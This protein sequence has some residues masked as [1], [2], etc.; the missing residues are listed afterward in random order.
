MSRKYKILIGGIALIFIGYFALNLFLKNKVEALADQQKE[1]DLSYDQLHVNLLRRSVRLDSINLGA[2]GL[3][4]DSKKAAIKGVGLIKFIFEDNI[5]IDE[6]QIDQPSIDVSDSEN[7]NKTSNKNQSDS[8]DQ[9]IF[10]KKVN[11]KNGRL[12]VNSDKIDELKLHNFRGHLD[13]IK[14]D[15][16]TLKHKIPFDFK[17][18]NVE[19]EEFTYKLNTLQTLKV[20]QFQIHTHEADFTDVKLLPNYSRESYVKIIPYQKDLMNIDLK[21]LKLKDYSFS[22]EKSG[23]LMARKIHLDQVNA[24]IYLN[25]LVKDD[26]NKKKLYSR[27]LREMPF[28][29]NIDTL[30]ISN[31]AINY[32]EVQEKTKKAGKVFFE[33]LNATGTGISNINMDSPD[34]PET[35]LHITSQLMGVAPLD[36][37]WRFSVNDPQDRFRIAGKS[38]H[39]TADAINNFFVA[40]MNMKAEGDPIKKLKFDFHGDEDTA[41]GDFQM[42]YDDLKINVLKKNG[43][44]KNGFLSAIADIFVSHKKTENKKPVTVKDVERDK[45]RSFWNYFW[46]AIFTGLKETML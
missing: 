41:G 26:P 19:G 45:K 8:L 7:S 12:S 44:E 43:E 18:Y 32:K 21:E 36:I 10:I 2:A 22:L 33:N 6:F 24:Y 38:Q 1:W 4:I 29:L 9:T 17:S 35:K 16:H 46:T 30:Q 20:G 15:K 28:K 34:F 25:K 31:S 23:K 37:D 3:K 40:G 27:T 5:S 11:L 39:I 14:I 13:S 42:I